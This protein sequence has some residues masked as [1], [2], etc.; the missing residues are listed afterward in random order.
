MNKTIKS[1]FL[2]FSLSVIFVQSA[3]CYW[4]L[5]L[6]DAYKVETG[7]TLK[8]TDRIH[9]TSGTVSNIQ[10]VNQTE[11]NTYRSVLKWCGIFPVKTVTVDVVD[12]SVVTLGGIPF[13][14]K[15]YTDGVL[16][17]SFSDV[18]TVKGKYC[19]AQKCGLKVGDL[20]V[21]INGKEVFTNQEVANMVENCGGK[22]LTVTIRRDNVLSVVKLKPEKSHSENRY[23]I[24][25]WVRDSSAGVGTLTFYDPKTGVLAGL[26]HPICDVDT[27]EIMPISTGELVNARIFGVK[28]SVAGTPGEL[29]GGFENGTLGKL[30]SN[31]L[32]GVYAQATTPFVGDTV[33]VAL[34]QEIK[35]GE[36]Y[37][38]STV[39]GAKPERYSILIKQI[40]YKNTSITRNMVIEITDERL[41]S[42]TGGIVQGMSGS[43]IIQNGKLV[44]AVTHVLVNDPTK[45][46]AIFAENMLETAQ[47]VAE[48]QLKE[49][50]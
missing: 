45:G 40:N 31:N 29:H 15:L 44:G 3:I 39:S 48:E 43:P 13:G 7:Q 41:L 14:I 4:Q 36:A 47:S 22:E 19:P 10:S 27:G 20:I 32:A 50:S 35:E 26:G 28:K 16:V 2:F 5:K 1:V 11:Q 37:I 21:S 33:E 25:L 30:V 23:K 9:A 49:A 46:Y 38:Y 8:I 42:Q 24:G 17:V 6:P 18:D 34:K 12:S